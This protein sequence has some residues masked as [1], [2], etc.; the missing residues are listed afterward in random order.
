MPKPEID[1]D[2]LF[3]DA[4]LD[5]QTRAGAAIALRVRDGKKAIERRRA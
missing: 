2:A 5:A 1:L 3:V 4:L